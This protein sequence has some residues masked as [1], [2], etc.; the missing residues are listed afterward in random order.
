VILTYL[1]V[2]DAFRALPEGTWA[3]LGKFAIMALV[4]A[5]TAPFDLGLWAG[6]RGAGTRGT[7]WSVL[8]GIAVAVATLATG[9]YLLAAGAAL[10]CGLAVG[11]V[12]AR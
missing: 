7:G 6:S 8:F 4:F 10:C 9:Q 12:N 11:A 3:T 2:R 1:I 5:C